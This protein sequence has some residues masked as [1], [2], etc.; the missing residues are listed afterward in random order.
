MTVDSLVPGRLPVGRLASV[1][2]RLM[3]PLPRDHR[4][5]LSPAGPAGWRL[6]RTGGAAAMLVFYSLSV[7][8]ESWQQ[9]GDAKFELFWEES[10]EQSLSTLRAVVTESYGDR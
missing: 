2:H 6:G 5:R 8:D 10:L 9:S 1:P 7:V 3:A 4:V